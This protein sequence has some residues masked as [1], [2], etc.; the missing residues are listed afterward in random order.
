MTDNRSRPRAVRKRFLGNFVATH[1][2]L[3]EKSGIPLSAVQD[4]SAWGYF[5]EH[6]DVPWLQ[7]RVED[8]S[9]E[10]AAFFVEFVARYFV[11]S[12]DNYDL[13]LG[14]TGFD[15]RIRERI[16]LLK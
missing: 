14:V 8:I 7:F 3:Y 12:G 16:S 13:S 2:A 6:G 15:K 11:E 5:L 10:Q 1:W 9:D 4:L